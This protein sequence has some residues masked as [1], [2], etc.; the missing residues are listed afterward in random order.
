MDGRVIELR[1]KAPHSGGQALNDAH[2]MSF[3]VALTARPTNYWV[4]VADAFGACTQTSLSYSGAQ[5]MGD[6]RGNQNTYDTGSPTTHA[7]DDLRTA[8]KK[9]K[10]GDQRAEGRDKKSDGKGQNSK[11]P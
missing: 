6:K 1:A 8:T 3:A 4:T 5:T 10:P 11:K 9:D 7:R 2:G